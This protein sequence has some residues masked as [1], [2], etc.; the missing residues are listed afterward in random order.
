[1]T[2][3]EILDS[4]RSF[5]NHRPVLF[6]RILANV[7][8]QNLADAV[9][10]LQSE[11]Q[12][13]RHFRELQQENQHLRAQLREIQ[14]EPTGV[15]MLAIE[16]NGKLEP[17]MRAKQQLETA[18]QTPDLWKKIQLA[19]DAAQL[20]PQSA[21]P[22]I[23]RGQAYLRLVSIAYSKHSATSSYS[24]HIDKA[25]SDFDQAAQ[26]DG[27]NPWAWIGKGDVQ[28]WL[29][30]TD[31]AAL[32]Y[33]RALGLD[34]FFDIARQR[35]IGLYTTQARRQAKA[36]QWNQ[37]LETLTKLLDG[38]TAES[39]LPEQKEAYLLR[40]DLLLKLNRSEQA[41]QDLSTVI[42]LDPTNVEAL[43]TRAN[44][45]RSRLQ[46]RLAKDDFEQACAL[47]S[48]EACE[49]LP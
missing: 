49:Q 22:L 2:E 34:P 39:W 6:M 18:F 38:K 24:D 8:L 23:V 20:D 9:R 3:T 13:A 25:R 26:L 48:I 5:A 41:L 27:K 7:D 31:D 37:S 42:K 16:P 17:V 30:R 44:L 45:Y 32:C 40:S 46:G 21:E 10:R 4:A 15:R 36:K 35:L 47:G 43:V 28:T 14:Q 1:M 29:K 19:S 11:A 12:M 33:E